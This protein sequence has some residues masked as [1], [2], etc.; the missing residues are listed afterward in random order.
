[1]LWHGWVRKPPWVSGLIASSLRKS[2]IFMGYIVA[3]DLFSGIDNQRPLCLLLL[4]VTP[5]LQAYNQNVNLAT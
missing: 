4:L 5:T 3:I 1:M 2:H